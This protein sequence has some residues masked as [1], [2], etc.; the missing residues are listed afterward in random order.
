MYA[1]SYPF[2]IDQS[3]LKVFV[4]DIRTGI[5]FSQAFDIIQHRAQQRLGEIDTAKAI[6]AFNSFRDEGRD[7]LNNQLSKQGE[8]AIGVA[9]SHKTWTDKRIAAYDKEK[10][11]GFSQKEQFKRMAMQ[12]RAGNLNQLARHEDHL[13]GRSRLWILAVCLR[14]QHKLLSFLLTDV[15]RD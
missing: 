10:L 7:E 2:L 3:F 5:K 14:A 1:S 13:M 12:Y 9:E 4:F 11:A 15:S 8:D 6:D